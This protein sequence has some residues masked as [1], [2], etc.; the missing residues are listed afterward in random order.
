MLLA[1]NNARFSWIWSQPEM[2]A[3]KGESMARLWPRWLILAVGAIVTCA[4]VD[5]SV[6][7]EHRSVLAVEAAD[8]SA[9]LPGASS[10]PGV[11]VDFGTPTRTIDRNAIGVDET[12]F[13]APLNVNDSVAQ[14]ML[15]TLGVGYSRI[16]L[17]FSTPND[18]GSGVVCA[19]SGC[20][21]SI[22]GD[23]WVTMQKSVGEIPVIGIADTM[24]P[25]DA[26]ALVR[27]VN[28]ITDNTVSQWVIGN[29]PDLNGESAAT[30]S[31]RFNALYDAMKA[32]DPAHQDRRWH[33]R[34]V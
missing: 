22:S 25:A 16:W 10:T 26:A 34:L 19:A 18:P 17:R 12:T 8:A 30:Y 5:A 11:N 6:S 23:T 21:T 14:K 32:V 2:G 13:G 31:A 3:V 27:H 29:E 28:V 9:V 7:T 24:S 33:H 20:D 15:G 1:N 4:V